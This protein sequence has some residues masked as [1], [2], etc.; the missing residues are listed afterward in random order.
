M[1][2]WEANDYPTV[3]FLHVP[4]NFVYDNV[5]SEIARFLT[6][7]LVQR[8]GQDAAQSWRTNGLFERVENGLGM[9][10]NDGK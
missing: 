7:N 2:M 8:Y 3:V 5:G 1:Q 6:G 9:G 4:R 10:G